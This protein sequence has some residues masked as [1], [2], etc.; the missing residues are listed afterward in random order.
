MGKVMSGRIL[1]WAPRLRTSTSAMRCLRAKL[2][3]EI[4][5]KLRG[6]IWVGSVLFNARGR[7]AQKGQEHRTTFASK[8]R[9]ARH[10]RL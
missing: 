2:S 4:G 5:T 8:R 10:A 9:N 7:G 6:N 1:I 3:E